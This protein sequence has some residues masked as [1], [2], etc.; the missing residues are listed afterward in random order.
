[1]EPEFPNGC[2]I[3]SEPNAVI[4]NGCYVIAKHQG[5]FIFRQLWIDDDKR[6]WTLKA[7][8]KDE[9][10]LELSGPADIHAR[11]VQ[12]TNGRRHTR[13]SYV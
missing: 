6:K 9:P 5:E 13:K 10:E 1:M 8:K 4:E 3:V 11:V 2:V 12:S 7:L